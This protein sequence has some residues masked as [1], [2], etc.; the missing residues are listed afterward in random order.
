M[1]SQIVGSGTQIDLRVRALDR[2][3]KR[4]GQAGHRAS[5]AEALSVLFELA[6]APST[7]A[8][9]LALLHELQVH[10][11]ELELQDE[12]LRNSRAELEADLLRQIELYD[13]S[14]ACCFTLDETTALC[15]MNLPGASLL[16]S[17]RSEL[18]GRR[19]DSFLGPRS[20]DALATLLARVS[21]GRPGEACELELMVAGGKPRLVHATATA[22]PAGQRFLVALTDIGERASGVK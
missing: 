15:E 13:F 6:S 10:Q 21:E 1:T 8:D 18:F 9:A 2:L 11:V 22:D 19:L 14:P 16:G 12:E 20:A 7:A 17:Q 4:S 3:A 5:A